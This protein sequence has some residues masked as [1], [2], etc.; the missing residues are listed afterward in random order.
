MSHVYE[1]SINE[2][3]RVRVQADT[4]SKAKSIALASVAI[5]RLDVSEVID[6][7]QRGLAIIDAITGKAIA[8]PVAQGGS[9]G[10]L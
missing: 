1:I 8:Q 9:V 2:Q 5:R 6:I 4:A 3:A 10:P 7:T